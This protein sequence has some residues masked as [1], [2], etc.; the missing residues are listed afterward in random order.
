MNNSRRQLLQGLAFA[1]LPLLVPH[2]RPVALPLKNY[3]LPEFA[4]GDLVAI[5]WEDAQDDIGSG[6]DFGEIV[7][8]RWVGDDK[9]WNSTN[10]LPVNSWVFFVCWTH[11]TSDHTSCY[12]CY[13][14]DPYPASELRLSTAGTFLNVQDRTRNTSEP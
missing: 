7:G 6:T 8:M 12:P 3:P 2:V 4:L 11:T 14:E 5:D 9:Q 13:D 10:P 1:P